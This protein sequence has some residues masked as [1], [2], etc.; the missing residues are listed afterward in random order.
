[1]ASEFDTRDLA[2]GAV[3]PDGSVAVPEVLA[4]TSPARH[5]ALSPGCPAARGGPRGVGA[6]HRGRRARAGASSASSASAIPRARTRQESDLHRVGTVATIHKM[7]KQPDGTIRLVVQGLARVRIVEVTQ[8]RPFLQARVEEVDDM[9][10]EA[11]DLEA[12]ALERNASTLFRQVVELS[13][14]LPDELAARGAERHRPRP[15]RGCRRG[16]AA[17]AQHAAQ[18]GAARDGVREGAAGPAGGC[19]HQGSRGARA[20]LEDPVAGGVRGRQ[21]P[22]RVLPARAAQGDPEGARRE[23]RARPGDL[24]SCG[25]RSRP[26]A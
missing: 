13:P 8:R 14:F 24:T 19:P 25:R 3:R 11:G 1:M 18:A 9:L 21:G 20:G 17:V 6:S 22:A 2:S 12:E 15:A 5:R 7:I 26:P 16:H 10:P 23:R 4:D